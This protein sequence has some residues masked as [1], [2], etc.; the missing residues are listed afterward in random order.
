[1]DGPLE[2]APVALAI[3]AAAGVR[4]VPIFTSAI[5]SQG[6][7]GVTDLGAVASLASLGAGQAGGTGNTN[8]LG[9]GQVAGTGNTNFLMIPASQCT[10]EFCRVGNRCCLLAF[11]GANRG[12]VCPPIC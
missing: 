6:L 11:A 10:N 5:T 7:A 12:F 3:G 2:V 4:A 9:A 8:F 1:M